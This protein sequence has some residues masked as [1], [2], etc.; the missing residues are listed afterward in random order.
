MRATDVVPTDPIMLR[1]P[2]GERILDVTV[3]AQAKPSNGVATV[4]CGSE[5]AAHVEFEYLD[6]RQGTVI[7]L[8]HTASS[9]EAVEAAGTIMGVP[10]GVVRVTSGLEV[11]V[12]LG[13]LG[14]TVAT[15]VPTHAIPRS[16][17][18]A[19]GTRTTRPS[20]SL[21]DRIATGIRILLR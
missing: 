20:E 17:R 5:D 15:T 4:L 19:S 12:P 8:L 2:D 3:L 18:K 21:S 6:P 14:P 7:E 10:K 9:P 16:L 11:V 13:L 1:V